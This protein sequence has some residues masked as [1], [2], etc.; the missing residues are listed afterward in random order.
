MPPIA[1]IERRLAHEPVH[2]RLGAQ[3]AVRVLT[4]ELHRGAL[5]A[6]DFAGTR[7]DDFRREA[8]RGAPPQV[9]A[10]E[11]L[12][13]VLRLGASG[14]RLNVHEGIVR[15]HLAVEHALQLELADAAF[16]AHRVALDVARRGL[17]VLAFRELEQLRGIGNG[18]A[19]AVELV[20]LGAQLRAFAAELLRLVRL[21]PDGGVFQL[22]IDLFESLLLGVVLKET[23]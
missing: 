1:G 2:A 5:D 3:P 15:V 17:I 19:G 4:S 23:P 20:D 13:P 9:H 22:A 12:R 11:H 8:A 21:L 10:Q 14:A 16:E 6:R 7:I 18:L